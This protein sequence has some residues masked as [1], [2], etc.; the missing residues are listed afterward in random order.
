VLLLVTGEVSGSILPAAV[1]SLAVS[2]IAGIAGYVFLRRERSARWLGAKAQRPLSWSLVKLKR[3][4]I[5]D[6]AAKATE[7]RT[8]AL[9]VLRDG[10][11]LGSIRR[12]GQPLHDLPDPARV[13]S[14]RRRLER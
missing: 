11:A 12:R 6:G 5:E 2:A 9:A 14:L 10:W 8:R 7:L 4:P 3:N 13:A 1:L